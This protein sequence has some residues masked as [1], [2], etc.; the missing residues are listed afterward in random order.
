LAAYLTCWWVQRAGVLDFEP[1]ALDRLTVATCRTVGFFFPSLAATVVDGAAS[2]FDLSLVGAGDW[3][4]GAIVLRGRPRLPGVVWAGFGSTL[5]DLACEVGWATLGLRLV[6]NLA[7]LRATWGD[8]WVDL[9]RER[10]A[11]GEACSAVNEEGAV[12]RHPIRPR[13]S[14]TTCLNILTP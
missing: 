5:D 7:G 1:V 6:F 8:A 3:V 11:L 12:D 4:R 9:T 2:C 14:I 13:T 10:L